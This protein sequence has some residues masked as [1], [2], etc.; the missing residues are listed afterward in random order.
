LKN[1]TIDVIVK[2]ESVS[3]CFVTIDQLV[4]SVLG[5][6]VIGGLRVVNGLMLSLSEARPTRTCH[7][8]YIEHVCSGFGVNPKETLCSRRESLREFL[9]CLFV[10]IY[11]KNSG[12]LTDS[13]NTSFV[14]YIY[15]RVLVSLVN[16]V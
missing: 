4:F 7:H 14:L 13:S 9:G 5:L 3:A 15:S 10:S 2:G 6:Y 11:C 16:R 1:Y 8:L 12:A